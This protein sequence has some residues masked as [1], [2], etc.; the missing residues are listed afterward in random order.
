M[1]KLTFAITGLIAVSTLLYFAWPSPW[2]YSIEYK[3]SKGPN[4]GR[5]I[6]VKFRVNRFTGE[7]DHLSGDKWV[8][9]EIA[10]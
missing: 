4:G 1:R 6:P 8:E 9:G 3:G 10:F 5:I 7:K 2:E